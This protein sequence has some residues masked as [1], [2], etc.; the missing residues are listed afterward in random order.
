MAYGLAMGMEWIIILVIALLI[1]GSRLPSLARN[2]GRSTVEFKKG[3]KEGED[4][5]ED[6][7]SEVTKPLPSKSAETPSK[8]EQEKT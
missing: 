5:K 8:P 4:I 3:M 2:M 7:K 1:F 6:I